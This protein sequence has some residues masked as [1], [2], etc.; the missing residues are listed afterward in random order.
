MAITSLMRDLD[1][2]IAIINKHFLK[3]IFTIENEIISFLHK[4]D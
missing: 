1:I 2:Q 3:T 4:T